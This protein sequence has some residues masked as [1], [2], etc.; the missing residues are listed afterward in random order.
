MRGSRDHPRFSD[1]IEGLI[2]P[3]IQFDSWLR[4]I[5][6]ERHNKTSKGER[7]MGGVQGKPG[8]SFQSPLPAQ[9]YGTR[10]VPVA[11]SCD[12]HM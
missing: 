5:T 10:L 7:C 4:F 6:A 2:G 11:T 8:S 1:R 3:S 12:N 9:S